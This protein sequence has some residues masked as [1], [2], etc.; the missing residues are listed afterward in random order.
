[1]NRYA[2]ALLLTGATFILANCFST[3][4]FSTP[5]LVGDSWSDGRGDWP[6]FTRAVEW[7]EYHNHAIRGEWLSV[8]DAASG[9]GMAANIASYLDQYPD[10][11]ALIIQGGINDI[12]SGIEAEAMKSA[13][14]YMVTEA[15]ARSHI[16]DI[17]VMSPG[18]F[19]GW[20]GWTQAMQDELDQYLRWLPDFCKSQGIDC[21]ATYAAVGHPDNPLIIS[22][23]SNGAPAYNTD[24]VHVNEAGAI[25]VAA[26]MDALIEM[27][28]KR[29]LP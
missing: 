2:L 14:T 10:A 28:R 13:L 29:P 18:P 9:D 8:K 26:D 20:G 17:I 1:L 27:I 22:D 12:G 6:N 15:K 7:D 24:G 11:D 21:Y 4:R 3:E 16:A 19:G 23:G 25:K 5:I